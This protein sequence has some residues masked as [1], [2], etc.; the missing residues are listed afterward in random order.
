MTAALHRFL[1][2]A[3][4]G[5]LALAATATQASASQATTQDE[6][7]HWTV[8]PYVWATD[9]GIDTRVDGRQVVDAEIPVEDLLE[10]LDTTFQ[11]RLE[12]QHG[13]LG[14]LLD[15]FA[16]SMSDDVGD[17]P[18]PMGAGTGTIDWKMDLNVVD[19]AALWDPRGDRTGFSFLGGVRI[20]DQ[21]AEVDATFTT[22]SGT[23]QESYDADST[24]VDALVGLRYRAELTPHLS[25]QA[26]LDASTGGTDATWSA[27]PSL[28]YTFGDGT[29]GLVAGY[30]HLT[31]DFEDEGGLD[32]E[33]SLSGPVFGLRVSL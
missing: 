33:M 22:T 9:V 8:T 13:E 7:W 5:A 16:V 12:V 30:R 1:R 10:D 28:S 24:L 6:R 11:G 14:F 31:V 17:V 25:L 27:F 20:L 2:T 29:W 4:L 21:H 19:L 23:S 15:V 18:L 26:Q 32:T 3:P